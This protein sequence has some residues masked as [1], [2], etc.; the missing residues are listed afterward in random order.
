MLTR[1]LSVPLFGLVLSIQGS[2]YAASPQEVVEKTRADYV[3]AFNA[4]DAAGVAGLY[5]EEAVYMPST[6]ERVEGRDAI[7]RYIEAGIKAGQSGLSVQPA[8]TRQIGDAIY[9]TGTYSMMAP[10]LDGQK[11]TVK[12]NY[13]VLLRSAGDGKVQILRQISNQV[14]PSRSE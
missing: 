10:G 13:L 6:G 1:H 3:A 12:G 14:T 9:E 8:E 4:G 7:K 11:A 2:A 5:T